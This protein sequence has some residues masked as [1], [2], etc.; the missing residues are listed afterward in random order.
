MNTLLITLAIALLTREVASKFDFATLNKTGTKECFAACIKT[1]S[2]VEAS[3][4][5]EPNN[6][7]QLDCESRI[8]EPLDEFKLNIKMYLNLSIAG[9]YEV[10]PFE[11]RSYSEFENCVLKI[12]EKYNLMFL[13][14]KGLTFYLYNQSY[15]TDW[16]VETAKDRRLFE[17]LALDVCDTSRNLNKFQEISRRNSS[18]E[19]DELCQIKYLFDEEFIHM[20]EWNVTAPS[21]EITNCDKSNK[22]LED[23]VDMKRVNGLNETSTF[24]GMRVSSA[25]NCIYNK[26]KEIKLNINRKA[27]EVLLTNYQLNDENLDRLQ[28]I[29]VKM[30]NDATEIT[31]EC[32]TLAMTT[33]SSSNKNE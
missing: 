26:F 24:F 17:E 3:Y 25:A 22:D 19:H 32:L 23:Y 33:A 14:L 16:Q 28:S 5:S 10:E 8:D 15:V 9:S 7:D 27:A 18:T 20:E 1:M 2:L 6:L 29:Y 21:H 30:E 11:Q 4:F 12:F 31:F 13:Y